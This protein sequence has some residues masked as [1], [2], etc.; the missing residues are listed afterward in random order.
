MS[1]RARNGSAK[2]RM[3]RA[4]ALVALGLAV[5]PAGAASA[6]A[7]PTTTSTV[8]KSTSVRPG[9]ATTGVPDGVSLTSSG[10]MT[11]TKA[12]TV[13]EA[14]D[15]KG[16]VTV[17]ATGVVIKNSRVSGTGMW[18]VRVAPG[19][20]LTIVDS[21]ITGFSNALIGSNW[22]ARGLDIYGTTQ[23]GVKLG[24]NVVLESSWIHDLTPAPGAHADGAQA[25]A[26]AKNVVVRNNVIDASNTRTGT[27]GNAAIIIKNDLGSGHSNGPVTITGNHLNGGNFTLFVVPGSKGYTISNVTVTNNTFGPKARYG[28]ARVTMPVTSSGNTNTTGTTVKV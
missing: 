17:Q 23:D 11:V 9:P 5:T 24:N 13:I 20:S 14:R 12:N 4:L 21:E 15:I 16:S 22:T 8:V 6:D 18:G 2:Q 28:H 3:M 1:V 7:A 26:S 19:G 27:Y 10:G 25:E